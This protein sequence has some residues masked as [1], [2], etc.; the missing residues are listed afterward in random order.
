MAVS[1]KPAGNSQTQA[2]SAKCRPRIY[3]SRR[4][5]QDGGRE[6]T[7]A[8]CFRKM[9]AANIRSRLLRSHFRIFRTSPP[10]NLCRAL[11]SAA[12]SCLSRKI[13]KRFKKNLET[14]VSHS[15]YSSASRLV[16]RSL[17]GGTITTVRTAAAMPYR[18]AF[19]GKEG[20]SGCPSPVAG[21]GTRSFGRRINR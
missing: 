11:G 14:P 10:E 20:P 5:P 2:A 16:S 15:F 7:E 6:F 21:I 13:L 19:A 9:P 12:M 3:G 1:S 8:V 18:T 4:L 17:I